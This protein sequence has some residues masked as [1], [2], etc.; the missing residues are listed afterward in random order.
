VEQQAAAISNDY[1]NALQLKARYDVLVKRQNL[2]FAALDCWKVVAEQLPQGISLQRFSFADGQTLT[3]AGVAG[4]DQ[5]NTLLDFNSAM[6]KAAPN[7]QPMF[8]PQ[9]GETVHPRNVPGGVSWSFS[10]KLLHTEEPAP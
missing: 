7:G 10:L 3:L 4:Q 5:V 9:G 6:Q 2:K 1:T 8:D